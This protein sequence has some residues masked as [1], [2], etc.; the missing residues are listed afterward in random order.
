MS[1]SKLTYLGTQSATVV[2]RKPLRDF[3][4]KLPKAFLAIVVAPTLLA[5]IY[6]AGVASPRYVS[7]AKFVVR[8]QSQQAPSSLG[9]ALQGVGLSTSQT[10]AFSVH[11]YIESRQAIADLQKVMPLRKMLAPRGADPFFRFPRFGEGR[12]NEDLHNAFT[13]F[14]TVG[15]DSTTGISTLRV[16]AFSPEDARHIAKGLLGGGE[17]LVNQLNERSSSQAVVDAQRRV[18]EAEQRL[19]VVQTTLAA[20]RNREGLIDP[21]QTATEGGELIGRLMSSLAEV[22]AE[23][24]QL[25]SGAPQ[26]PQLSALDTRILAY[27]RQIAEERAKLVGNTTSLAP[28]IGAYERLS[29]DQELAGREVAAARSSLDDARTEARRQQLYLEQVVTPNLPDKATEPKRL[30][31]ILSVLFSTLL[32]Y[33][34]G[35][36]IWAG[37][38]EH[39]QP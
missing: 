13:R 33:G 24:A 26:S 11:Q 20:F 17:S 32:A 30:L 14:I 25:S 7:E 8:S 19:A 27:E 16:E 28:K 12:T 38:R 2:E 37:V 3:A 23:R 34:V 4:Q 39:H 21:T 15:Y 35:W 1:N 22:R 18:S 29:L 9:F 6:F 10:D 31:A 5:T 36:L